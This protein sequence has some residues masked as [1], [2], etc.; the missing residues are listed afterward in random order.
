MRSMIRK[1]TP[2]TNQTIDQVID[3]IQHR[4]G[5]DGC[6]EIRGVLLDLACIVRDLSR[7]GTPESFADG[8]TE[9]GRCKIQIT[10]KDGMTSRCKRIGRH[11]THSYDPWPDENAPSLPWAGVDEAVKQAAHQDAQLS[12][13]KISQECGTSSAAW[14]RALIRALESGQADLCEE[15][16]EAW[17]YRAMI[18]I[19]ADR[20]AVLEQ[21]VKELSVASDLGVGA[22]NE[23]RELRSAM[24]KHEQALAIALGIHRPHCDGPTMEWMIGEVLKL[25]KEHAHAVKLC[26]EMDTNAWQVLRDAL[27]EMTRQRDD[28][29]AKLATLHANYELLEES[30]NRSCEALGNERHDLSTRVFELDAA[31]EKLKNERDSL[32]ENKALMVSDIANA[33]GYGATDQVP[34]WNLVARVSKLNAQVERL[35]KDKNDAEELGNRA[36]KALDQ[37][38]EDRDKA[39]AAHRRAMKLQETT[40]EQLDRFMS[41]CADQAI[42]ITELRAAK[43][44]GLDVA[45]DI[46]KDIDAIVTRLSEMCSQGAIHNVANFPSWKDASRRCSESRE[47]LAQAIRKADK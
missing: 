44:I 12:W 34:W 28:L 13:E 11:A 39:V 32:A 3:R 46:L 43:G 19:S 17:F 16:A 42:Q 40:Q 26:P 2:A 22:R 37:A 4:A 9:I 27:D 1:E 21:K 36:D 8:L 33:L 29:N 30:K 23:I 10:R 35:I 18:A 5:T 7:C 20:S 45:R 31:N 15:M 6:P 24:L 47:I 41:A 25:N 38:I 14:A